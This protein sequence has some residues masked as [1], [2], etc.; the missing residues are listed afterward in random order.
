MK[1]IPALHGLFP[2]AFVACTHHVYV[3]FMSADG[4]GVEHVPAEHTAAAL[5]EASRTVAPPFR[6]ANKWYVVAPLASFHV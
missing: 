3:P 6:L 1:T 2:E 5:Y 4:C